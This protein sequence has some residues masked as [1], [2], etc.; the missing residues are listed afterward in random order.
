ML[1]TIHAVVEDEQIKLLEPVILQPG[2]KL[3]VTI[4]N[5]SEERFWTAASQSALAAIWNN[6]EDDIYAELLQE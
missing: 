4:L 2:Q 1:Q 5:D 3:L 6:E